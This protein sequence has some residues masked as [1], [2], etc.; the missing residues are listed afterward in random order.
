MINI[1]DILK[2]TLGCKRNE[3]TACFGK[4]VGWVYTQRAECPV[5]AL[6]TVKL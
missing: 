3:I 6:P 1:P 2:E 4:E 5:G